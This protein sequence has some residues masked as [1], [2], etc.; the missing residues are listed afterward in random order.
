MATNQARSVVITGASTGIGEACALRLDRQGW[1]V[2]AGVRKEEDGAR[3]KG[4]A[5]DRLQPVI[6]DVTDEASIT[7]AAATVREAVGEGGV[8]GLV[9][10]AGISVVGPLEFLMP[11]DL[12]RQL[13]VNVIGQIAVTREFLPL[14]RKGNGRIVNMGSIAG[15]MATPFLGPYTA[16]KFA[17]EALTDSLRQELRPWGIRVAIVEPGSIA[18]PIWEKGQTMADELEQNLPE[19]AMALYGEAF[20]AMRETAR[21]FEE[22]GIPPDEVAKV[23]EHALTSSRPKPRYVVGRDAQIQ[24]VIAKVVP[25]S[26][27]DVLVAQQMGLPKKS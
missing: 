26:L 14:I 17:M 20:T 27:R 16:S 2:F 11:E 25:D 7:S 18:T 10:N 21:K 1:R 15:K 23:V 9:N 22:A 6:I 19:E 3:V 4:Q 13:E 5:S 24:R 12:R 8:A